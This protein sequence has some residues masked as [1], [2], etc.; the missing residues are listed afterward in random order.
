MRSII[1]ILPSTERQ[2][3]LFSATQTTAITDLARISLRAGPLYI[4]VDHKK[5][6]ST[7]EGLEQGYVICDSD[8]RFRLLFSFLKKH[9]KKK[10]IVFLSSCNS[11]N[12]YAELLNYIDLPV[13]ELHGKLK[14]QVRTNRFFEVSC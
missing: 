5:E 1:K 14:Q 9:Q 12:F 8:T 2:T 4:N 3:S 10:V 13:L 7:V 11:V 6:Y